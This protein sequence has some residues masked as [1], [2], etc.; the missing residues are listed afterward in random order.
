MNRLFQR[1]Q[2]SRGGVN[3]RYW[4]FRDETIA[5]LVGNEASTI[6]DA[7]CGEGITLQRLRNRFCGK[8][9]FGVDID[10]T[11][12]AICKEHGLPVVKGNLLRL[13]IKDRSVDVCVFSEVIEHIEQFH[14][15]LV[16][17]RKILKPN[18]ALVV[19]I[20]NDLVFFAA[21][22]LCFKFKEAFYDAGHVRRWTPRRLR[23]ALNDAGFTVSARKNVP[24]Y[25]WS[26]SLH[27]ITVAKLKSSSM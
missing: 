24:F 4:R 19:V 8:N 26:L 12:I 25:F 22:M 27:S 20:P 21:R 5:T 3:A 23:N 7:G 16:E 14:S 1:V 15:A 13:G 6:V 17:L 2:F 11:N 18:G 9:V 10:T